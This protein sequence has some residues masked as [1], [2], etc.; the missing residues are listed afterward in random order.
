MPPKMDDKPFVPSGGPDPLPAGEAFNA[1]PTIVYRLKATWK[2]NGKP[3][4]GYAYS[5]GANPSDSF[6]DYVVFQEGSAAGKAL[7]FY[8]SPP[9]EYGWCRWNIK[10]DDWNSGY[11]L[12][13]KATGYLYRASL[14]DTKFRIVDR[15][16]FCS[17][18]STWGGA[19]VGSE[20]AFVLVSPGEYLGTGLPTFTCELEPV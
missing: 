6:W 16:L 12:D 2:K 9:D 7:K 19:P 13:C 14:Y 1:D 18:S 20:Y 8:L 11:H 3:V 10:D 4:T 15:Q 5:V 17:Y